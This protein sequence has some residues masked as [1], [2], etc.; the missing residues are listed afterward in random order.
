MQEWNSSSW[1]A[2]WFSRRLD[3]RQGSVR[4]QWDS[5]AER[6]ISEATSLKLEDRANACVAELFVIG[7]LIRKDVDILVRM[8]VLDHLQ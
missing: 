1:R 4:W 7:I 8:R 3:Q 5:D 6:T 2:V